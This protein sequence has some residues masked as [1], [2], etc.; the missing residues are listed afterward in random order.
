MSL[1]FEWN[2]KKAKSNLRKHGCTFLEGSTSFSDPFSFTISDPD[3]SEFEY[4]FLHLGQTTNQK[5]VVVSFAE[6]GDRI[7]IISVR[8]AS[9]RERLQYEQNPP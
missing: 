9:K 7:R 6:R 1:E 2:P 3:H 8:C 4:R 5:L